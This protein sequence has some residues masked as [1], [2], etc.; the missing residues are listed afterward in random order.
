[1]PPI[2]FSEFAKVKEYGIVG[3]G[4]WAAL[5]YGGS[6]LQFVLD[7]LGVRFQRRQTVEDRLSSLETQHARLCASYELFSES[8]LD[9]AAAMEDE[10]RLRSIENPILALFVKRLKNVKRLKDILVDSSPMAAPPMPTN[11]PV[12]EPASR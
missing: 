4:C 7:R 1:M 3:F 6:V 11:A 10:M 8:V 12:A 2:D 9:T 5:R